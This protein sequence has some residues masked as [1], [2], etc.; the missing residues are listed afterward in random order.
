[1]SRPGSS[2][3]RENGLWLGGLCGQVTSSEL[4]EATRE[5]EQI[6]NWGGI[7]VGVLVLGAGAYVLRR[8]LVRN[9]YRPA[10]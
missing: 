7:V 3:N 8:K 10:P 9:R 6:V 5:D 2:L 1:M 4:V